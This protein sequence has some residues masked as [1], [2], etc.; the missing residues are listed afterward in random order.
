M[1]ALDAFYRRHQGDGLDMIGVSPDRPRDRGDVG[2]IMPSFSYP[3]AML[4]EA[5]VN[6]FGRPGS[7]PVTYVIAPDATLR[8]KFSPDQTGVSEQQ[9]DAAVLPLLSQVPHGK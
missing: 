6:G 3:A 8:A 5:T 2:K 7:I 9:L 1:A 4:G